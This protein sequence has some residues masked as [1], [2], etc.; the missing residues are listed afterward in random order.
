MPIDGR[1]RGTEDGGR[2]PEA[3]QQ[4]DQGYCH[5][6][7]ATVPC[8]ARLELSIMVGVVDHPVTLRFLVAYRVS[9]SG[10]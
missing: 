3:D 8:K 2:N 7:T 5:A 1:Y 9:R 4:A 10:R 6:G